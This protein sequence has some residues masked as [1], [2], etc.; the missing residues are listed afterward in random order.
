M[1]WNAQLN[2]DYEFAKNMVLTE[3]AVSAMF[4]IYTGDIRKVFGV[5]LDN[6]ELVTTFMRIVTIAENADAVSFL[7]EAW[8]KSFKREAGET[9]DSMYAQIEKTPISEQP[10]REEV[11]IVTCTYFNDDDNRHELVK[12]GRIDRG[13]S[14]KPFR[15]VDMKEESYD[16]SKGIFSSILPV[17]RPTY[18][19]RRRARIIL[20]GLMDRFSIKMLKT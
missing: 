2:V 6:K 8:T 17:R 13:E 12:M 1:D 5:E 9:D 7:A 15:I 4:V 3:G 20:P 10:G 11:I 14:G 19:Q 16:S 18:A